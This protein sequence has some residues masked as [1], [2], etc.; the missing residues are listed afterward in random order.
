M[1]GYGLDTDIIIARERGNNNIPQRINIE[2]ERKNLIYIPP[3]AYYEA[4]RG[5]VNGK[6]PKQLRLLN[7]LLEQCPVG[8]TTQDVFEQAA[9]IYDDLKSHGYSCD[10]MDILIASFC[11]TFG[12]TLVTNN[13]KHFEHIDGLGME[14]W[15]VAEP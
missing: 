4:K 2:I 9:N 15:S 11:M 13:T 3:F 14:D 1:R 10:D 5:I 8:E 7:E 6:A 12:L